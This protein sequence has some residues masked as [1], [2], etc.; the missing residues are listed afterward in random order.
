MTPTTQEVNQLRE[1]IDRLRRDVNKLKG[2]T[3]VTH[4]GIVQDRSSSMSNLAESTIEGFNEYL[5]GLR[6]GVEDDSRLDYRLTLVQF[7][8]EVITCYEDRKLDEVQ[9]LNSS[10]YMVRG[11]TALYDGIGQTIR[12]IENYVKNDNG[13]D[14]IIVIMTDGHENASRTFNKGQIKEMIAAKEKQDW[15]FVFMGAGIDAMAE[16]AGIG[17]Q[18]GQTFSYAATGGA[19]MDSF[20]SLSGATNLRTSSVK[21][22]TY[23]A[24]SPT[25]VEDF[26]PSKDDDVSDTG[27]GT[28]NGK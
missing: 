26:M 22:G 9:N 10:T 12:Q 28:S 1:E 15:Q 20:T 16:G 3:G 14:A 4:I 27:S 17:L 2:S 5:S 6:K 18:R 13:D 19:T 21:S 7:D 24:S 25:F 23:G 11:T 8:H